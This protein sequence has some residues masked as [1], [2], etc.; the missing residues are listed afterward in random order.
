MIDV[1]DEE[2]LTLV[3][4]F[5][6][7]RI[8]AHEWTH[9]AHLTVAFYY[10]ANHDFATARERMRTG[11]LKLN[12][13]HGTPETETRGYHE[14]LTVFWLRTVGDFL[15]NAPENASLAR[16]AAELIETCS[17]SALPLKFYRRETL[18][19]PAARAKYLEPD[20]KANAQISQ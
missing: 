6:D 14:T 2:I 9:R 20:L 12:R 8:T 15:E 4:K 3:K 1:N 17:D 18:F 7:C 16:L 5:E 13:A 19:S 11:I 10:V